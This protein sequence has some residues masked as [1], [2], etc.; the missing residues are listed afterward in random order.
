E[1]LD[2]AAHQSAPGCIV[3]AL[4]EHRDDAAA[5]TLTSYLR[6]KVGPVEGVRAGDTDRN[7]QQ[8]PDHLYGGYEA[9]QARCFRARIGTGI[10]A[11]GIVRVHMKWRIAPGHQH[12]KTPK[13]EGFTVP[14]TLDYRGKIWPGLGRNRGIP[15]PLCYQT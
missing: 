11:H 1:R 3:D 2:V 7:R 14:Q 12:G 6:R 4:V 15:F 13:E 8:R 9:R 10:G 5:Q